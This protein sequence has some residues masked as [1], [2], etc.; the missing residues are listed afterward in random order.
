MFPVCASDQTSVMHGRVAVE[1]ACMKPRS[2]GRVDITSADPRVAPHIDHRYLSDAEGHDLTVLRDGIA[3]ANQ[4]LD[5]PIL[6][7]L[8][9]DAIADTASDEALR[10]RVAHYYH[11]VG[12]C[13]MGTGPDSVC[14][15]RGRVHGLDHV[16]IADASII[17]DIPR[18][19]TNLPSIMIGERIASWL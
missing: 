5:H 4:L 2:R 8:L 12:T 9:G 3:L 11:P 10:T 1:V 17:P 14:D 13:P 15:E 19:N 18:A 16:V 6:A 7:N